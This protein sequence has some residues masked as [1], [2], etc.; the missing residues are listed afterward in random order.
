MECRIMPTRMN[1]LLTVVDRI[2]F[3]LD[4]PAGPGMGRAAGRGVPAA[5]LDAAP[6][7]ATTPTPLS[8]D[9]L[10]LLPLKGKTAPLD[11]L[12]CWVPDA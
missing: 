11:G 7:G 9:A 1:N 12:A 4:C 6:A 8:R 10:P 3:P 5:T 2:F